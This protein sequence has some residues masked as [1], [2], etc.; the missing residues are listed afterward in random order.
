MKKLLYFSAPWCA[1]CKMFGPKIQQ[2]SQEGIPVEKIDVSIDQD[3]VSRYSIHSVP[4]VILWENNRE[5]A[6]FTGVKSKEE[7]KQFYGQ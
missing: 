1:P 6:R 3:A 4:T 2:M 7:I 5:K